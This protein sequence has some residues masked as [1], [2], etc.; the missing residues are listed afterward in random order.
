MSSDT[1]RVTVLSVDGTVVRLEIRPTSA[2]STDSMVLTRS[3]VLGVLDEIAGLGIPATDEAWVREH[4]GEYVTR[5]TVEAI[6]GLPPG[7]DV[8]VHGLPH[9]Q[10]ATRVTLRAELASAELAARFEVG[11]TRSTACWDVWWADPLRP[12]LP[13]LTRLGPLFPG[14]AGLPARVASLVAPLVPGCRPA[15]KAKVELVG[16]EVSLTIEVT[17]QKLPVLG[18]RAWPLLTA[19]SPQIEALVAGDGARSKKAIP[20]LQGVL[21]LDPARCHAGVDPRTIAGDIAAALL[22]NQTSL[23]RVLTLRGALDV[24]ERD[25]EA[26][27]DSKL[28]KRFVCH[29]RGPTPSLEGIDLRPTDDRYFLRVPLLVATG[30]RSAAT[31]ALELAS[32]KWKKRPPALADFLAR[33]EST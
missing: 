32:S 18:M 30:D 1:S 5:T 11:S 26:N 4:V 13:K 12:E 20:L 31:A 6:V 28:K 8:A 9:D 17:G 16:E 29:A 25:L 19:R 10:L 22:R 23:A 24:I 27:C 14:D 21:F 7:A 33:L 15:G 2:I 3:F